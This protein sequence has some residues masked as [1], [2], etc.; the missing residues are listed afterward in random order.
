MELPKRS[1]QHVVGEQAVQAVRTALPAEWVVR[2]QSGD[3]GVDLEVELAAST[4]SGRLFKAQVKG[5]DSV[6]WNTSGSFLQQIASS[7]MN[8]WALMPVPVVVFMPLIATGAVHWAFAERA[9]EVGGVRLKR[10]ITISNSLSNLER[11]VIDWLDARNG[12]AILYRIPL[13]A[14]KWDRAKSDVGLDT[15]SGLE[16]SGFAN[17]QE[18][19]GQVVLLRQALGLPYANILP[20]ELWPARSVV[21]F[22]DYARMCSGT[23]DEMVA[24]LTPLV[25]EALNEAV[26][27]LQAEEATSTNAVAKTWAAQ[28]GAAGQSCQIYYLGN[29]PLEEEGPE[30]WQRVDDRLR[31]A[32]AFQF[33]AALGS[34]FAKK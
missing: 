23:F 18:L 25:E 20:W 4:V 14:E 15:T 22:G 3:Y 10:S 2:E 19:Y 26:R 9:R 6:A 8:Y 5:H 31:A 1:V 7:T 27:R 33:P 29:S 11:G 12:N 17:A 13:F 30:F 16:D 34:R 32:G 21:T 24:Y 28:V